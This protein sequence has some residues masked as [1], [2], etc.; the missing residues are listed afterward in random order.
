MFAYVGTTPDWAKLYPAL[1]G[2]RT[3][4]S[5]NHITQFRNFHSTLAAR[6]A[7]CVT[8]YQFWN[9]PSGCSWINDGCYPH[10]VMPP[11]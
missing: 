8:Y 2:H 1:P 6:Y 9:E 10:C 3:P 4:P 7:G 11:L 5:E